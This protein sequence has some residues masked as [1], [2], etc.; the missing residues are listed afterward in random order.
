MTEVL[1]D[2]TEE[3]ASDQA[4]QDEITEHLDHHDRAGCT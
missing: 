2:S 3:R 1:L 4:D